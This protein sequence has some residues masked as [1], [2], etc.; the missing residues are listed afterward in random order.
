MGVF[1]F[2]RDMEE[3]QVGLLELSAPSE[4]ALYMT[5]GVIHDDVDAS[6]AELDQTDALLPPRREYDP[7][8][9][10]KSWRWNSRKECLYTDSH[11]SRGRKPRKQWRDGR[12][13]RI[14]H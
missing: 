13:V 1:C 9:G 12:E 6:D 4:P 11:G 8:F 10:H 5:P 2:D 7:T 3:V 14:V